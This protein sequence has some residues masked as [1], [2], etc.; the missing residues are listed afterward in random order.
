M[1]N[2]TI[3]NSGQVADLENDTH[4]LLF[5]WAIAHLDRE[6]R[7]AGDTRIFRAIVC[8]MLSHVDDLACAI[9]LVD[10]VKQGLVC[11]YVDNEGR[12]VLFFPSFA[13]QQKGF[14]RD[15]ER[16][17]KFGD[18]PADYRTVA[19]LSPDWLRTVAGLSPDLVRQSGANPVI[20][21]DAPTSH[22]KLR[23]NA[24]L[25]PE[26]H[27][28]TEGKGREEKS[29]QSLEDPRSYARTRTREGPP[30][31]EAAEAEPEQTASRDKN[32]LPKD[33]SDPEPEPPDEHSFKATRIPQDYQPP[34]QSFAEAEKRPDIELPEKLQRE[35][36]VQFVEYY[37]AA[38]GRYAFS[39]DWNARWNQWLCMYRKRNPKAP[40]PIVW[41]PTA[42]PP[43]PAALIEFCKELDAKEKQAAAPVDD[44]IEAQQKKLQ[45][46]LSR[47]GKCD[48]D[49]EDKKPSGNKPGSSDPGAM[50]AASP[51]KF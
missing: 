32:I 46:S 39:G 37:R 22:D 6:G 24:G 38:T 49:D 14:H 27:R 19:G 7:I 17:S 18:P 29:T 30:D 42:P 20:V 33:R 2:R 51:K 44:S 11:A 4:R 3:S 13:D 12:K 23:T 47:I 43:K 15:R 16:E 10:M 9:A 31:G 21:G 26:K 36:V 48:D 40:K 34:E 35:L 41:G 25:G 5:T 50:M 45:E 28:R 1:L 8:P